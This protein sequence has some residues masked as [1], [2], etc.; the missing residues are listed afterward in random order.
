MERKINYGHFSISHKTIGRKIK[1]FVWSALREEM[2]RGRTTAFASLAEWETDKEAWACIP[3]DN[4]RKSIGRF[5]A[6]LLSVVEQ[7]GG[8]IQHLHR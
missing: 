6:R 2:Y 1:I 4:I 8:P 5:R 3:Q 7:E